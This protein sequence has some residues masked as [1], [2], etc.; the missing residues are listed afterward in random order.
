MASRFNE[1]PVEGAGGRVLE[2]LHLDELHLVLDRVQAREVVLEH[3][4][5]D[6]VEEEVR[7]LRDSHLEVLAAQLPGE[8]NRAH[9]PLVVRDEVVR[10]QEDVQLARLEL[11][12]GRVEA[13][14]VDDEEEV[15]RVVV[16]LREV[17]VGEAVLDRQ[18]VEVEGLGQDP[19]FRL[20][21]VLEVDPARRLRVL[22]GISGRNSETAGCP[23][24]QRK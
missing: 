21:R 24:T 5:E 2:D 7:T 23:S 13:D 19:R 20:A 9:R 22:G 6:L 12:R 15:V 3:P 18:R 1:D 16:H 4:V 17:D 10:S 11:V 14:P 8:R